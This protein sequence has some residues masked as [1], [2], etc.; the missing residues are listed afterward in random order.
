MANLYVQRG[1][2]LLMVLIVNTYL[3]SVHRKSLKYIPEV[4]D[5]FE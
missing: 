3:V 5:Y 4:S 2:V 1:V